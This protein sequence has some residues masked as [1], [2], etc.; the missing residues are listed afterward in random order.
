MR[1]GIDATNLRSGGS[2]THIGELLTAAR[3]ELHGVTRVVIWGGR[4]VL[5]RVPSQPWL[6]AV[7][8][9]MLD[10]PLPLRVLWQQTKL[11]GV[12]R[13]AACDLLFVPGGTYL[14]DFRPFVTMS[15]NMLP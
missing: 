11:A 10:G 15:Q 2:L 5:A 3:P 13:R 12:A 4:D 1:I 6:D 7:H 8:E 9:P 14:G